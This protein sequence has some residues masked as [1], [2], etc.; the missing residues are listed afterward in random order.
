MPIVGDVAYNRISF[1]RGYDFSRSLF[2]IRTRVVRRIFVDGEDVRN[3][4][5]ERAKRPNLNSLY[6]YR[7]FTGELLDSTSVTQA[8]DFEIFL[9]FT[10]ENVILEYLTQ[11]YGLFLGFAESEIQYIGLLARRINEERLNNLFR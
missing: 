4:Q 3:R 8:N 1:K 2:N 6:E 11:R 5:M 9:S 10:R 7:Y